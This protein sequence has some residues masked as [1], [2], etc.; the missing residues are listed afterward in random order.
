MP[1]ERALKM[2]ALFDFDFE[3]SF[4]ESSDYDVK[5]KDGGSAESFE[6]KVKTVQAIMEP[7]P[8][9]EPKPEPE[10]ASENEKAPVADKTATEKELRTENV[11]LHAP[12]KS[13]EDLL[14]DAIKEAATSVT[15]ME[16]PDPPKVTPNREPK[17]MADEF[18]EGHEDADDEEIER[19]EAEDS[20][21]TPEPESPPNIAEELQNTDVQDEN[22]LG[23]IGEDLR[24]F[25]Y[26]RKKHPEFT[27]YNGNA[28]FKDFYRFKLQVLRS[29]MG[30]FPILD[31]AA[32]RNE[33]R[34]TN[35]NHYVGDAISSGAI[36]AKLDEC[37]R[38]RIRVAQ[39]MAETYEQFFVWDKNIELLES[40]LWADHES[41][42][43]HKRQGLVLVHMYQETA[44]SKEMHGFIEAA[45]KIDGLLE[46]ASDSLS[47]Q[48]SCIQQREPSSAD[49]GYRYEQQQQ[50][51]V[52]AAKPK[53]VAPPDKPDPKVDG[54]DG[55]AEGSV[56]SV[57]ERSREARVV[58]LGKFDPDD[59]LMQ[60]S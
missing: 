12:E 47:R 35:C 24:F 26:M 30:R 17:Q 31:L 13:S 5:A 7:E 29:T 22:P 56:I 36:R 51:P 54:L 41:R 1:S 15:E 32:R 39:M 34:Q 11:S 57:P 50:K 44:Y 18:I 10:N 14:V 2:A 23:L 45:K 9:P 58:N 20:G 49:H 33:L 59:E 42:G 6:Q 37:Y 16:I 55:I 3:S 25:Q 53:V 27:M 60:L 38:S 46:A 43:A 8:E 48:L 19:Q 28:A 21:P 52:I 40:K 4:E